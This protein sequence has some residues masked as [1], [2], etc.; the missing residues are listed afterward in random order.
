MTDSLWKPMI[1]QL[2]ALSY[3]YLFIYADSY[4]LRNKA[5]F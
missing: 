5:L 1:K 4:L 3:F 2:Q